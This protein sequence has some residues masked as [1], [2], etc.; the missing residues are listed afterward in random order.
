MELSQ[1]SRQNP[2]PAKSELEQ[3]EQ[4]TVVISPCLVHR[5]GAARPPR[6]ASASPNYFSARVVLKGTV[7]PT[8]SMTRLRAAAVLIYVS[9]YVSFR[10]VITQKNTIFGL[11][12]INESR[13][14]MQILHLVVCVCVC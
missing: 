10:M 11:F 8:L 14:I 13:E 7:Y 4:C 12:I 6:P 5:A 9:F 1:N 3:S 2:S